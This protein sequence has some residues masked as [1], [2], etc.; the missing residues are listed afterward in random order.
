MKIYR[1]VIISIDTAETLYEDSFEYNGELALCKKSDGGGGDQVITTRY[2]PYIEAR[3]QDFLTT[4]YNERVTAIEGSPFADYTDVEVDVA[5]FGVGYLISSF[6]SLYD[7][8]GK[9]MAGLDIEVL[10][11]QVF[12]DTVNSPEVNNLVAAEGALIDDEIEAS[13]IPRLQTGMRDINSVISSSFVVGKAL[14]EDARTK[15]LAKFSAQLKYN[16][17]PVAQSRWQTHLEWNKGVVGIYAE[18]MKFYFAAKTDVDDINYAMAV[19]NK[20]WPFT[21][22]DFERAALGALQGA[23]NSK[24]N[25]AGASTTARVLSGALSGAAMGAMVGASIPG[26][27]GATAVTGGSAAV[28][29]TAATAGSYA[30]AGA[31]VGA[32]FGI[33]AALTY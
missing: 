3:H 28:G 19:K 20:L 1:K 16:L 5:F 18:I 13:S 12:E 31:L 15:S 25:V 6:P 22:L 9:F 21:V 2:A 4:V 24:E 11:S 33:G 17:I 32:A 27:Y 26:T 29:T 7:M 23:M 14:I 30:G 10:W 8:Y